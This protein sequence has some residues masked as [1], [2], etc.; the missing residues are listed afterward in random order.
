MC[1]R[2]EVGELIVKE[3][4]QE[5]HVKIAFLQQFLLGDSIDM[6]YGSVV[7]GLDIL[8]RNAGFPQFRCQWLLW[9]QRN[10]RI[11]TGNF[12]SR[13]HRHIS[14]HTSDLALML[15]K[16]RLVLVCDATAENHIGVGKWY[17]QAG[18]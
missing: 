18:L 12:A 2:F 4:Q 10:R 16:N 17:E 3:G 14:I 9:M 5:Q 7:D 13:F 11:S 8:I 15:I 6:S 1:L